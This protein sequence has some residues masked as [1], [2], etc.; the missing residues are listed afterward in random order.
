MGGVSWRGNSPLV[1]TLGWQKITPEKKRSCASFDRARITTNSQKYIHGRALED[2]N[3]NAMNVSLRTVSTHADC[4][5]LVCCGWARPRLVVLQ[6][7]HDMR[8]LY[9]IGRFATRA[10]RFRRDGLWIVIT[11]VIIIH[12]TT[13][14]DG[15]L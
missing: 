3:L 9:V 14:Q 6:T 12:V 4:S 1:V 2:M 8:I 15:G 7:K 11:T 13:A 10:S 5:L